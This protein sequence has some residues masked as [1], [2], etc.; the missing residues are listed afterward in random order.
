MLISLPARVIEQIN[1]LEAEQTMLALSTKTKLQA[2]EIGADDYDD[3]EDEDDAFE[4]ME[5]A[6][7]SDD[8]DDEEDSGNSDESEEFSDEEA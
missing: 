8:E 3:S 7:A 5:P 1:A 4:S 2:D 6:I